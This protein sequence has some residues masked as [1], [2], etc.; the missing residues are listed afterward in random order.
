MRILFTVP[1]SK[2]RFNGIPD[3]GQGYLAPA[4]GQQDM[5]SVSW[6]AFWSGVT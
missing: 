2:E 1:L 3:L 5:R 4:R 6:T